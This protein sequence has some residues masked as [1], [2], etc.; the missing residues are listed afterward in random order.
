[1]SGEG[2]GERGEAAAAAGGHPSSSQGLS[3]PL[4]FPVAANSRV[5][6]VVWRW[7]RVPAPAIAVILCHH[8]GER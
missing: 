3:V 4:I 6:R 1:M 5:L 2:T 8:P 7:E